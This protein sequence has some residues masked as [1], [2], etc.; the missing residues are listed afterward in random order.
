MPAEGG[1]VGIIGCLVIAAPY[2]R[3]GI[4][5]RLVEAAGDY[6]AGLGCEVVEAYPLKQLD[7]DAHGHFGPLG[8]YRDLGYETYRELPQ[9]LVLRKKLTTGGQ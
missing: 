3:H 7:A 4:A 5:R 1:R 2:R 6:L 9:R 8:V